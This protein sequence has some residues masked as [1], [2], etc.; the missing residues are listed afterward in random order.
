MILEP[1]VELDSIQ[2]E[3][4]Q[5][6]GQKYVLRDA[7]LRSAR[8]DAIELKKEEA[9]KILIEGTPAHWSYVTLE[10][11]AMLNYPANPEYPAGYHA[12][13]RPW[14]VSAVSKKHGTNWGIIYPDVT[15]SGCLLYTS[16]SPR[17]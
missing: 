7:M 4:F 16:P 11:G 3:L 5:L 2:S 6:N 15:G 13:K 1:G 10:N 17:D 9:D 12:R 8:I 14:Y